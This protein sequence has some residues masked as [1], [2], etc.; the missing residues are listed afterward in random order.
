M[1]IMENRQDKIMYSLDEVVS[2]IMELNFDAKFMNQLKA[3]TELM[4]T[5]TS[6]EVQNMLNFMFTRFRVWV[7]NHDFKETK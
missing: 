3:E 4:P 7:I 6:E 2:L 5:D 1:I